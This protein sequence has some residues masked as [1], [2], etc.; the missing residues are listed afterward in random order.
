MNEIA[1]IQSAKQGDLKAFNELVL[2][3]E[4]MA[5]NL[6]IRITNDYSIASDAS[7]NAFISAFKKLKTFRGDSFKAWLLRIV[8]NACYD[9]LRKKKRLINKNLDLDSDQE[10]QNLTSK[11][12]KDPGESPEE[13]AQRKEMAI[14]IQQCIDNLEKDFKQALILVDIQGFD[15]QEASLT[16]D[17][18]IGT[19]RSRLSRARGIVQ[20]C[21]QGVQE[22]LPSKYRLDSETNL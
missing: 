6:A 4:K 2:A 13:W 7:Q 12:L 20:E 15:Y 16:M 18:P 22:L 5:F 17:S 14:A 9:E 11:W 21:L 1:L 10:D 3:H 8:T 19:L